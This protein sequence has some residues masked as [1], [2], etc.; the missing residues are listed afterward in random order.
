MKKIVLVVLLL[1]VV[2]N[3]G[4]IDYFVFFGGNLKNPDSKTT[5]RAIVENKTDENLISRIDGLEKEI[6]D[7]KL[8]SKSAVEKTSVVTVQNKKTSHVTYLPISGSLSQIAYDWVS[9]PGSQFNFN[10]AS[11]SGLKEIKFESNMKLLNGNGMAFVRLFDKTHG[12]AVTKSQ[13]QTANQN[14]TVITSEPINFM[15]GNNL[16]EVQIKSLT[17]DSTVFNSGKLVITSEY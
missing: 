11:Y 8:A 6:I 16:I 14:D 15:D 1:L 7:L 3:L 2:I 5:E 17:A 13:V 9:V 4:V 12:V 10:K